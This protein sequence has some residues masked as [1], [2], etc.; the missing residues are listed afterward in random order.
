MA[1]GKKGRKGKKGG[2][3]LSGILIHYNQ[4]SYATALKQLKSAT[5]RPN[6]QEAANWLRAYLPTAIAYNHF[7]QLEYQTVIDLLESIAEDSYKKNLLLGLSFLYLGNYSKAKDFLKDTTQSPKNHTLGFYYLLAV[8]YGGE[9]D[10]E[11][12]FFEK[13]G[14]IINDLDKEKQDYLKVIL[15]LSNEEL[16]T[17]KVHLNNFKTDN[18]NTQLLKNLIEGISLEG[19]FDEAKGL[20]KVLSQLPYREEEANHLKTFPSLEEELNSAKRVAL[21]EKYQNQIA[22]LC[23]EGIPLNRG[24]FL[25]LKRELPERFKSQI[26]YNQIVALYNQANRNLRSIRKLIDENAEMFFKT[27]ESL[28]VYLA[29]FDIDEDHEDY[30]SSYFW[31]NMMTY[32]EHFYGILSPRM[33]NQKGWE[34]YK[35][36]D[37][38]EVVLL[39]EKHGIR[40]LKE[41]IR[42]FDTILGLQL[43][44][45][46]LTF[47][48]ID[49]RATEASLSIFSNEYFEDY[50]EI[51]LSELAFILE[52]NDLP[53]IEEGMK[54]MGGEYNLSIS[55]S[56][57]KQEA[58]E[59][60]LKILDQGYSQIYK[61]FE[62]HDIH[63]KAVS[64]VE[65]MNIL[66]KNLKNLI[67]QRPYAKV[68]HLQQQGIKVYQKI[69]ETHPQT[70][71]ER[72]EYQTLNHLLEL[73]TLAKAVEE[74]VD[75]ENLALVMPYVDGGLIEI[76]NTELLVESIIQDQKNK[77][78]TI[79]IDYL[80]LLFEK[81]KGEEVNHFF[82][83]E[84]LRIPL[85]KELFMITLLEQA[86][87]KKA[88]LPQI[89]II[90]VGQSSPFLTSEENWND[91]LETI[92][93]IF[94]RL[95][96]PILAGTLDEKGKNEIKKLL[97]YANDISEKHQIK[98]DNPLYQKL[99]KA[100]F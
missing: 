23:L 29:T 95:K 22:Q 38:L 9:V 53:S 18:V 94:E 43:K 21:Q 19:A 88:V 69:F 50:A 13:Y 26:V 42:K 41:F 72:T 39:D 34:V 6:E 99:K 47:P 10:N 62:K 86:L 59:I 97:T 81:E 74:A 17:A 78:N 90:L 70:K 25:Y 61:A 5:I 64:V 28:E 68:E 96:K 32:F 2:A 7:I 36:L 49:Y 48:M 71:K 73:P 65:V 82:N 1:K 93:E 52:R 11:E 16:E 75:S 63:P 24:D 46:Q 35:A 83:E 37:S 87:R 45:F 98:L 84:I 67:F 15:A 40:Y 8:I 33:L 51:I 79:F 85:P 77:G 89:L 27:I 4:K 76:L 91:N 3:R 92:E 14:Y 12:A 58:L 100:L 44:D 80:E 54:S 55:S 56:L 60:Y 57:I 31:R 20:Y 30:R 66:T